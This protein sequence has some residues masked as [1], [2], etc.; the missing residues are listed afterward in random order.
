[1]TIPANH[2]PDR[3]TN[4][5]HRLTG[6]DPDFDTIGTSVLALLFGHMVR[7]AIPVMQEFHSDLFHDAEWLRANVT[8]PTT[9]DWL[10]RPSGTNLAESATIG[11]KI[12]PGEG[13]K[14]YRITL[15]ETHGQW[16][17]TFEDVPLD[18]V[19]AY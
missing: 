11:V 7:R 19:R 16:D 5:T 13:A 10:V 2:A 9:F 4:H 12:G 14:F 15:T 18:V 3:I 17:A 8:G 1:M 6:W